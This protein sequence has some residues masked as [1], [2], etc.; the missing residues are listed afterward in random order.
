MLTIEEAS[1]TYTGS[2]RPHNGYYASDSFRTPMTVPVL[3]WLSKGLTS[4]AFSP[5]VSTQ[6]RQS[7]PTASRS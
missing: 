7:R 3:S 6:M 4:H 1:G 2:L 5:S